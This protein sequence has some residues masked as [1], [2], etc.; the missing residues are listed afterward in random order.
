MLIDYPAIFL[1]G[2]LGSFGH[3]IG[4][5]GGFVMAYSIKINAKNPASEN[6][7]IT[8][9]LMYNI[10]RI[11]TYTFLGLLFGFV[12]ETV[13]IRLGINNFQGALQIVAGLIMI[14]MGLDF[15]GWIPPLSGNYFPGYS[16][17]KKLASSLLSRVNRRNVFALGLVLGFIP[18]GLVYAAGAKAAATEN[19]LGGMLTMFIFGLG[20]IPGMFLV[21]IGANLVT[22]KF[23]HYLFRLATVLV[24]LLGIYTVYKGGRA[25]VNP[26]FH[27]HQMVEVHCD[28]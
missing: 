22:V 4:M 25:I 5:C 28:P 13:G 7:P 24:I 1:I 23:R 3:C 21:G 27:H 26:V 17:F 2:F 14:W 15:G 12:G 11:L 10:G 20:T 8:P 18:C 16:H 19:V 6:Q 9:H